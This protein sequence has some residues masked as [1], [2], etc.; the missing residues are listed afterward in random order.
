V[1]FAGGWSFLLLAIFYLIVDV[2]KMRRWAFG[3]V[4]IGVNPLAAYVATRLVDCREI[5]AIFVG[6]LT[7][8]VGSWDSFVQSCAAFTIVWLILYWMYRTRTFCR[9]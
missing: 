4:V 3:F 1:L 8:F 9:I 2:W 5:G 7:R 6:G